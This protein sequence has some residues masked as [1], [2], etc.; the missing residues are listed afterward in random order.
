MAQ[1]IRHNL[2]A[3]VDSPGWVYLTAMADVQIGLRTSTMNA[4]AGG[5]DGMVAKEYATG[6]KAGMMLV[7]GLPQLQLGGINEEI[8]ALKLEIE[9][10]NDEEND[11]T[12]TND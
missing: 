8:E 1:E 6:E 10:E 7:L 3:L 2:Q 11:S 4:E 5:M 9:E 12:R